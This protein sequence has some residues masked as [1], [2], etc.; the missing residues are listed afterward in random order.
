MAL[1]IAING[2][3]LHEVTMPQEPYYNGVVASLRYPKSRIKF[4]LEEDALRLAIPPLL[5]M[6]LYRSGVLP[7]DS[8]TPVI[9]AIGGRRKGQFMVIDVRYP[10]HGGYNDDVTIS[11]RRCR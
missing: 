7:Q 2:Q 8:D 4:S 3:K 10:G 1:G 6:E 11:F 9:I 5:G